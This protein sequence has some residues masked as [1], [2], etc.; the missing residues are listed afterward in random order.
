MAWAHLILAAGFIDR[1]ALGLKLRPRRRAL[2]A[3][4]SRSRA[5]G[6]GQRVLLWLAQRE[7]AIGTAY[8]VWTG[9][10][11]AGTLAVG[12]FWFGDPRAPRAW[13]RPPLIVAGIIGLRLTHS[14]LEPRTTK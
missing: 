4:G 3:I 14:A 10:G 6:R 13:P 7:I 12:I 11:A 1:L 9:T 5:G 8:A 2:L